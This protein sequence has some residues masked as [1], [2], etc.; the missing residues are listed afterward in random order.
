MA[1]PTKLLQAQRPRKLGSRK[2]A[3]TIGEEEKTP[4][5]WAGRR[6][7]SVNGRNAFE[8]SFWCGTCPLLFKRLEGANGTLSIADLQQRLND[9]I[10]ELDDA[11][12]SAFSALLPKGEYLAM[13][14]NIE[15]TLVY[16]MGPG[17]YFA[18]DQD[19]TWRSS[20]GFWGLPENPHTPYYRAD[21]RNLDGDDRLFEF[22][23]P[24]VPPSWNDSA[25]V[26]G[27][28]QRLQF[29]NRPT[30]VALGVLDVRQRAVANTPEESRVHWGLVHF[31]LDGHHKIE[32]AANS[33]TRLQ[34]LSLISVDHSL[35]EHS[36]IER[37]VAIFEE[38][39]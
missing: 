27:H 12:I 11:V 16:P 18:E 22:V 29:S 8:L 10:S 34:I 31:L 2:P 23:V 14:L 9:G 7:L 13:L 17:D 36:Q 20:E 4:G 32:A 30:C 21:T 28:A 25:R 37:L 3:V 15:P 5:A 19:A 26:S 33:G 1:G 35:A 24:M 6:F 38:T 39:G